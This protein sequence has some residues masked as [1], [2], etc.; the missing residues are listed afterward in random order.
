MKNTNRESNIVKNEKNHSLIVRSLINAGFLALYC[1]AFGFFALLFIHNEQMA[2]FLKVVIGVAFMVPLS[3]LVMGEGT[4]LAK[5]E[6]ARANRGETVNVFPKKVPFYV[7]LLSV[8]PVVLI[9]LLSCVI[10]VCLG[11][12]F[13]FFQTAS[14]HLSSPI[15]LIF[16]GLGIVK[17]SVVSP[18]SLMP[19]GIFVITILVLFM[20]AFNKEQ[21]RLV[22]NH[23]KIANE[24]KFN[25]RLNN[26]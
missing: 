10:G 21:N 22:E 13:I 16:L 17:V 3:G 25:S 9:I 20:S 12:K 26:K 4:K 1:L 8:L 15:S 7:P 6:F 11:Q 14:I 23:K 5:S 24:I 2:G 18:V 19:I